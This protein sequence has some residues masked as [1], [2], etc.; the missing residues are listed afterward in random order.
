MAASTTSTGVSSTTLSHQGLNTSSDGRTVFTGWDPR[1][2]I[3]LSTDYL[4]FT[5]NLASGY[6]AQLEKLRLTS[7]TITNLKIDVRSNTDNYESSLGI[8]S[9]TGDYVNYFVNLSSLGSVGGQVTFR[10]YGFGSQ[11]SSLPGFFGVA[12]AVGTNYIPADG[13]GSNFF[14]VHGTVVPEPSAGLLGTVGV[15]ALLRRRR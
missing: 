5:L 11:S 1:T 4:Q 12:A 3:D 14:S 13:G 15:L 2:T 10:L 9:L 7:A 6:T 8:I